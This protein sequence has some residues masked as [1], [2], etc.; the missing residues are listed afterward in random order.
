MLWRNLLPQ[1]LG[2]NLQHLAISWLGTTVVM[3]S[4]LM[5]DGKLLS[6]TLWFHFLGVGVELA[7]FG[8]TK[9][10]IIL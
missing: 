8:V 9:Y 6:Y 3:V 7:L 2:Q 4:V 5:G 10:A 1:F